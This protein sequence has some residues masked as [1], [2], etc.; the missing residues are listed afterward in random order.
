[1]ILEYEFEPGQTYYWR[2]TPDADETSIE[3]YFRIKDYA[4][5]YAGEYP[6]TRTGIT[7]IHS[8]TIEESTSTTLKIGESEKSCCLLIDDREFFYYGHFLNPDHIGIVDSKIE[9]RGGYIYFNADS[10]VITST[11]YHSDGFIK[12]IISTNLR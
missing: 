3:S 8:E 9:G 11:T 5:I 7:Q 6:A 4:A 1:M 2:V 10:I 12:T